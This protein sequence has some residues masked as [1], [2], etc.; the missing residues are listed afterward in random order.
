WRSNGTQ[1]G[2]VLVKDIAAGPVTSYP[3]NL[4][5][6]G[7]TPYF[8]ANDGAHGYELWKSDGSAAGTLLVADI[9]P[10]GRS[11]PPGKHGLVNG[12][13]VFA[14]DDGVH[15]REMMTLLDVNVAPSF[16]KGADLNATDEDGPK[17]FAG[18]AT[19]ITVGPADEASQTA[20]FNVQ[21]DTNPDIFATP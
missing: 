5:N 4:T 19:G 15:G 9:K 20:A 17:T 16:T 21:T 13:L 10:G 18:W 11:S 14:A 1:A 3:Q 12:H 8:K 7:G 2:T 6:V